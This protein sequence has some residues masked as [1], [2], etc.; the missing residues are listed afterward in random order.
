MMGLPL[1]LTAPATG[2]SLQQRDIC[3]TKMARNERPVKV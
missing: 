1:G 2:L 3:K